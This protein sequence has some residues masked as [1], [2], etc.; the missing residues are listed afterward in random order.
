MS[1]TLGTLLQQLDPSLKILLVE[2]LDHVAHESTYGWNNAGT[3]HAG[4]CE[5]N[6]TPETAEGGIDISKALSINAS[7]EVTLQ[8]WASLVEKGLY[9]RL[10]NLSIERHTRALSGEKRM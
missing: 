2:R 10:R 7:F 5:L 9:P 8:F 1:A 3:G 4:Y 6:Y